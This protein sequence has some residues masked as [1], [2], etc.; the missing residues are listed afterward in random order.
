MKTINGSNIFI[1]YNKIFYIFFYNSSVRTRTQEAIK[2]N[3]IFFV[4]K[5]VDSKNKKNLIYVRVTRINF[6]NTYKTT[7][8][9]NELPQ[10]F[11]R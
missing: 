6:K 5:V 10:T 7:N 2:I 11:P 1:R 9:N 4:T 3:I 8:N